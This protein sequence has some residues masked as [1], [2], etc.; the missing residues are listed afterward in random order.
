MLKQILKQSSMGLF[1]LGLFWGRDNKHVIKH[2]NKT[3][4]EHLIDDAQNQGKGVILAI[5]HSGAWEIMAAWGA[6]RGRCNTLYR[7][8]RQ[9][10]VEPVI[11][12]GRDS[13]GI[14]LIRADSKAV[15]KILSAL[16]S[17]EVVGILPDQQPKLGEGIFAPFF[18]IPALTMTLLPKL[19]K[20]TNSVLIYAVANRL[21]NH[22]GFEV[23]FY[24]AEP[25][26]DNDDVGMAVTEMNRQIE[27]IARLNTLQYQWTYKRFGRRPPGE[28]DLY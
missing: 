8:P 7:P 25:G 20:K 11:I 12:E 16:K 24:P 3:H 22:A 27:K 18:G 13:Q 26:V 9:P 14:G 15:R 6:R 2:L 10:W 1:E 21:E 19:L 5:L 28:K 4:N 17:G 23:T